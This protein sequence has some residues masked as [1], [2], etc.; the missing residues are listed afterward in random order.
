MKT[1]NFTLFTALLSIAL[2]FGA[3]LASSADTHESAPKPQQHKEEVFIEAA[4]E[5]DLVLMAYQ[6]RLQD[7]QA[8][9]VDQIK[10][11]LAADAKRVLEKYGLTSDELARYRREVEA[12]TKAPLKDPA[13]R[14]I[15][16][17]LNQ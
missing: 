2:T 10:I 15:V 9:E 5:L 16:Q 4:H 12:A 3:A 7:A 6:S 8:Y 17:K 1:H 13:F 11:N 14:G